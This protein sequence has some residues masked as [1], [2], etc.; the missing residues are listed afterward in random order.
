MDTGTVELTMFGAIAGW[1]VTVFGFGRAYGVLRT[2]VD[3]T[4][5]DIREL[6][7]GMAKLLRCFVDADGEPRLVS[8]T[9]LDQIRKSCRDSV[10]VQILANSVIVEKHDKKLDAIIQGLAEISAMAKKGN[11][12]E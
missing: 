3:V 6:N 12:S 5:S 4:E 7:R 8:Y 9:A 10:D 11:G 1:V 2:R